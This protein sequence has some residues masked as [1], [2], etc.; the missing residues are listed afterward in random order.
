[1]PFSLRL[2]RR[3]QKK[4][5]EEDT[6]VDFFFKETQMNDVLKVCLRFS[7]C[8]HRFLLVPDCCRH[9]WWCCINQ[10]S[11]TNTDQTDHGLTLAQTLG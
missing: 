2:L 4:V 9:G 7:F 6:A 11:D 1:M 8:F 3:R 5:T 10:L